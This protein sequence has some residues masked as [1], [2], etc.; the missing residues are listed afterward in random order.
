MVLGHE[1]A[2]VVIA[3]GPDVQKLQKGDRVGWGFLQSTC[4]HCEQCLEGP[5]TF[6]PQ[7][8]MYGATDLDQGS[9]A[10]G[11]V[12]KEDWLFMIPDAL[13]DEEAAPLMCAG[14]TVFNVLTSY[15]V[16]PTDKV[17]IIGIGGLGHLAIKVCNSKIRARCSLSTS[18]TDQRRLVC[19]EDGL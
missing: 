12:K 3:T 15:G 5:E 14:A 2:G 4:G 1:G 9:L 11:I 7:R 19:V 16:K 6:C 13:T 10:Y 8:K 17:G 18:D